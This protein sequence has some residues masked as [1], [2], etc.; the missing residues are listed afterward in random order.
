[1]KKIGF[2]FL[3]AMLSGC[4]ANM[5]MKDIMTFEMYGDCLVSGPWSKPITSKGASEI[6]VLRR[7]KKSATGYVQMYGFDWDTEFTYKKDSI[8]FTTPRQEKSA[9]YDNYLKQTLSA[10][11]W[12]FGEDM[13]IEYHSWNTV[14]EGGI[15]CEVFGKLKKE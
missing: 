8:I 12:I 6:K 9:P 7:D 13:F 4:S 10:K 15:N 14:S 1:M 2:I 3:I 11:G 5:T